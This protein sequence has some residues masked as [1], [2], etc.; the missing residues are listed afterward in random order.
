MGARPIVPS[1]IKGIDRPNAFGAEYAYTHTG[2][3]G[4]NVVI[5]G[6]G[7]VGIE[8]GIYLAGLGKAVTI[9]EKM[10]FMNNGGNVLHQ[11]ALNVEIEKA[12]INVALNVNAHEFTGNQVI[13][14][15]AEGKLTFDCD[16]FIYAIGQAPLDAESL[17]LNNCAPEFY[18]IGDCCIPKNIMQATSMAD[19]A[20]K[21]LSRY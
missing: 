11:F 20:V 9:I 2:D 15:N 12:K 21:D 5:M 13:A 16:T 19:A 6:A 4:K 10:P 1:V 17:A 8:L 14:E 3:I 18:R 7:L